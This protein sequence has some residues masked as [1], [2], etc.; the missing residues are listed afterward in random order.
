MK[1]GLYILAFVLVSSLHANTIYRADRIH[2]ACISSILFF[3][4]ISEKGEI[5]ETPFHQEVYEN[6]D[7]DQPKD[8][9][10]RLKDLSQKL[11]ELA[12]SN[13]TFHADKGTSIFDKNEY[14]SP[15]LSGELLNFEERSK[16]QEQ[17]I[18]ELE[19]SIAQLKLN[20]CP[21]KDEGI[22]EALMD[23]AVTIEGHKSSAPDPAVSNPEVT[24]DTPKE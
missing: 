21:P 9:R 2:L 16:A 18:K 24:V 7:G 5:A 20:A 4:E 23:K 12:Q 3:H 14:F 6:F 13:V 22:P 17:K 11:F 19:A 10:K 15:V 8:C 1:S